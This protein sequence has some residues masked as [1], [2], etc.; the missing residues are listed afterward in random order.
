MPAQYSDGAVS[1]CFLPV[2]L[3]AA[4]PVPAVTR[5]IAAGA[6]RLAI[7]SWLLGLLLL[8]AVVVVGL[9]LGEINQ[10][11]AL[12]GGLRLP[13]L[14]AA[15]VLQAATYACAAAVWQCVLTRAGQ[16]Q[17]VAGLMP[18]SLAKLFTDQAI[19]S[20]GLSGNILF[21]H[22]M[23]RRG[24]PAAPAMAALAV[25]M[26][27][28]CLANLPLALLVG[29]VLA[30]RGLLNPALAAL[31]GAYA[32]F[33]MLIA[34]AVWAVVTGHGL[35]RW[36]P[37]RRFPRAAH[38]LDALARTTPGM[39]RWRVM[40]PA[41]ALQAAIV[42][43]DAATLWVMLW[44][45]GQAVA[46]SAGAGGISERQPSDGDGADSAWPGQLRGGVCRRAGPGRRAAGGGLAGH[47]A[48]A[49]L[50][51]VAA[52]V[53][54]TVADTSRATGRQPRAQRSLTLAVPPI[55]PRRAGFRFRSAS[56]AAA[57]QLTAMNGS[58]PRVLARGLDTLEMWQQ[59]PVDHEQSLVVEMNKDGRAAARAGEFLAVGRARP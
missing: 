56:P 57:A 41:A 50:H 17:T 32:V 23:R 46:P 40:L 22:A 39:L 13:W 38:L 52:D 10:V 11:V 15:L 9:H 27:S 3:V 7:A 5:S 42:L 4:S 48:A 54:G 31:L 36:L 20:G 19:P 8:V 45:L 37:A 51:P 18:L 35:P 14:L 28:H 55:R 34:S 29:I 47:L 1:A 6:G 44:A 30:R 16:R 24:V 58:K 43:C 33:A 25:S 49:R 26:I 59:G 21:V 53:A 2:P 12:L